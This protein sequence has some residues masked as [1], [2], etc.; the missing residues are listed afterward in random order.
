M[1]KLLTNL[2]KNAANVLFLKPSLSAPIWL[3]TTSSHIALPG[4]FLQSWKDL[5][6]WPE[7]VR[8][9]LPGRI[10]IPQGLPLANDCQGCSINTQPLRAS[11]GIAKCEL[12]CCQEFSSGF[13]LQSLPVE[14]L[15]NEPFDGIFPV[16]VLLPHAPYWISLHFP[17]KFFALQFSLRICSGGKPT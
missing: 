4:R 5:S 6:F 17:N 13:E 7:P 8:P 3:P 11:N 1:E 9:E 14:V 16:S 15:H 2:F 10:N 12:H